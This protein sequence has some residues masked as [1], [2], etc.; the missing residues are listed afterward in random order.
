MS[1]S[2]GWT[3]IQRR[4]TSSSAFTSRLRSYLRI[5]TPSDVRTAGLD[6]GL[7]ASDC[8]G[9]LAPT[10]LHGIVEMHCHRNSFVAGGV[11]SRCTWLV[12]STYVCSLQPIA[13]GLCRS[14]HS[15]RDSTPRK[16]QTSWL[17]PRCTMCSV[18]PEM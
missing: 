17:W 11:R 3:A 5:C 7:V 9:G 14:M 2:G 10:R 1:K 15:R 13:T 18:R 6:I 12:I 16:I 8:P 4:T